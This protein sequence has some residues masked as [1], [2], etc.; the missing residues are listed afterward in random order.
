MAA[1]EKLHAVFAGKPVQESATEFVYRPP[2]AV[3]VTGICTVEPASKLAEF[4]EGVK[5]KSTPVPLSATEYDELSILS[6]ILSEPAAGPYVWGK[7]ETE[8]VQLEFG[9]S[10]DGQLLLC[11]RKRPVP[12]MLM[13]PMNDSGKFPVLLLVRVTVEG[14]LA[15]PT[16]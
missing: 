14:V 11:M 9:G 16:G 3:T 4:A 7:K 5:E 15:L 6:R 8:T 10:D 12:P 13:A 2:C 1:G